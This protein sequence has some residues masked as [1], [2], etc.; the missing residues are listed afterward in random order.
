RRALVLRPEPG[1]ARTVASLRA[2]EVEAIGV[3]LFAVRA[4]AWA[5]PDPGRFDAVLLTSANAVRFGGANLAALAGLPVVA[6]G[7]ATAAAARSAG[8]RV[9]VTGQV[10]AAA[11]IAAAGVYPR[12]L[13]LA[14]REHVVLPNVSRAIVYAS[15]AVAVAPDAL[16]AAVDG[17]VLLHSARAA[18][19]FAGLAA[20]LPRDRVRVAALSDAVA[21]V[22]GTGWSRVA[23]AEHPSDAR[24]V[25]AAVLL[26]IDRTRGHEDSVPHE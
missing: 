7:A 23:V 15:E 5:V 12:L 6:V 16:A 4:L 10:D 21:R 2:A 24:L 17:V 22:A 25:A 11:A 20:D 14:G 9:A 19:R 13:H 26:A 8:F 1:N 18:A 3:P